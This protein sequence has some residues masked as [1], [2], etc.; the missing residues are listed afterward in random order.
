MNN[1]RPVFTIAEDAT[2]I[3]ARAQQVNPFVLQPLQQNTI[4][5]LQ[6][7]LPINYSREGYNLYPVQQWRDAHTNANGPQNLRQLYAQDPSARQWVAQISHIPQGQPAQ[8][9]VQPW[10]YEVSGNW[11]LGYMKNM[12]QGQQQRPAAAQLPT[13]SYNGLQQIDANYYNTNFAVSG[14]QWPT[15]T[16]GMNHF[17]PRLQ[18]IQ[19]S[20]LHISNISRNGYADWTWQGRGVA[21]TVPVTNWQPR[22]NQ[23]NS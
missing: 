22:P 23:S 9:T 21:G 16:I 14:Y 4:H 17:E 8:A 11:H 2:A 20:G 19:Q 1:Q 10:G 15:A 5:T 7:R 13:W 12:Y 18:G 6:N 3:Q